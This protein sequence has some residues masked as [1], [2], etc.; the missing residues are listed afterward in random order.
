MGFGRW[1]YVF[2]Q[3]LNKM[4]DKEIIAHAIGI[5]KTQNTTCTMDLVDQLGIEEHKASEILD[6]LVAL[7]LVAQF[8][9]FVGVVDWA[10]L[11]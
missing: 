5:V 4:L 1:E 6:S 2:K 3:Y 7:E 9:G 10:E 8:D 11:N